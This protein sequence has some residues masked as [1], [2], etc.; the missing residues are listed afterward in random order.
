MGT[1]TRGSCVQWQCLYIYEVCYTWAQLPGEVV[2]NGN[3]YI[4]MRYVTHG[5]NYQGKLC[6]MAMFIYL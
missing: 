5:H 1:I 3:V 4:F 2:C 6:A